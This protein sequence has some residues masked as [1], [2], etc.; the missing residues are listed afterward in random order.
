MLKS[1]SSFKKDFLHFGTVGCFW[2][3]GACVYSPSQGGGPATPSS[4]KWVS[5]TCPEFPG[6]GGRMPTGPGKKRPVQWAPSN[7][8]GGPATTAPGA[9]HQ[10]SHRLP[11]PAFRPLHLLP[12]QG[13]EGAPSASRGRGVPEAQE[14]EN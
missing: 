3:S 7:S 11:A 8:Q 12:A 5:G 9:G 10:G 6:G 14:E 1:L 4:G 2:A 13:Q